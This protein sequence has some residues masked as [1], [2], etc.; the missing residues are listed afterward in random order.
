M[1]CVLCLQEEREAAEKEKEEVDKL[2]TMG[3]EER[4]V[5]LRNNPKVYNVLG[6]CQY[7][8]PSFFIVTLLNSST[9]VRDAELKKNALD[10][11]FV[12]MIWRAKRFPWR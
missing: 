11:R 2:R 6:Q 1:C 8:F 7:N 4:R 10:V 3:E 9:N 12:S 5:E